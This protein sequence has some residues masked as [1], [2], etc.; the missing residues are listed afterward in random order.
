MQKKAFTLLELLISITI[1]AILMTMAY[2]PYNYYTNKAKVKLTT[3]EISQILASSRNMAIHWID[4]SSWN[5]DI[6]VNF[7]SWANSVDIYSFAY[8]Y[9]APKIISS[10]NAILVKKH[11]LQQGMQIDTN[12]SFL[13][14]AISWSGTY[15]GI[16]DNKIIINYSF[17]WS[18]DLTWKLTYYTLTN[19][20]DY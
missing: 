3:K 8:N 18:H 12:A 2:A 10:P 14:S 11:N 7:S 15:S 4:S 19:V 20:S 16:S 1:A 6:L 5:V 17:K 13:F 9:S